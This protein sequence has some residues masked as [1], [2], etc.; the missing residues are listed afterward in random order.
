V[1]DPRL[2]QRLLGV[3]PAWLEAEYKAR[4][5]FQ[6]ER[7]E[8]PFALRLDGVGWG[9]RLQGFEWPRD[10]RVHRA[11]VRAAAELLRVLGG[12]CALVVSDEVNLVYA[13]APPYGGRVE[14][15]VSISA[16]LVSGYV[17]YALGRLLFLDSRV[18][19]LYSG[20]DAARYLLHRAR[21]GLNNY[22]SSLYHAASLGPAN[23]T[24]SLAEMIEA[25]RRSGRDPLRE[26]SWRLVGSCVA[27]VSSVRHV[28]PPGVEVARRRL[29][30]IDGGLEACLEA[31]QSRGAGQP[32]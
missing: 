4:E 17:S 20:A 14:K 8:P 16:G 28:K 12:C 19:K 15:L 31:A 32:V 24:P 27:Y 21:V 26:P 5:I 7:V 22:I 10:E 23:V 3:N 29:V 25:L 9:R 6:G 1:V 13:G 2:L 30:A 11:L 18:V